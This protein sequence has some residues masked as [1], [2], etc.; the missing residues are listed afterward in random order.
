VDTLKPKGFLE[1]VVA[2]EGL[3]AVGKTTLKEKLIRY[4]NTSEYESIMVDCNPS[5]KRDAGKI[6]KKI[7]KGEIEGLQHNI[8]AML[9]H[10]MAADAFH[11][12]NKAESNP[13][14]LIV[15]DRFVAS[16][17]AYQGL[18]FDFTH[19]SYT[20]VGLKYPR[21]T[22]YLDA[23]SYTLVERMNFR[24][25]QKERFDNVE[26]IQKIRHNYKRHWEDIFVEKENGE[27]E[28]PVIYNIDAT[29]PFDEV[30]N[31]VIYYMNNKIIPEFKE[32]KIS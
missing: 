12:Q 31:D 6:C 19:I 16:R 4:Y 32:R 29:Q 28:K 13:E 22:F 20:N 18:K 25:E 9:L 14:K 21:Y 17:F 24:S 7:L 30:F 27:L 23:P 11:F 15:V 1:N 5:I 3:D 2:I 10:L 8:D 26:F